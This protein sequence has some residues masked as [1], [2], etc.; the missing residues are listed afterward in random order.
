MRCETKF[1]RNDG[2]GFNKGERIVSETD[3]LRVTESDKL[4]SPH[5]TYI[6]L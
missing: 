2:D 6:H 1:T 3:T 5:D 4:L